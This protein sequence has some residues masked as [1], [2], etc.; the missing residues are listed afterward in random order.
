MEGQKFGCLQNFMIKIPKVFLP[1]EKLV[2]HSLVPDCQ[3]SIGIYEG[4]SPLALQPSG[5]IANPVLAPCDVTDGE[6]RLVADPFGIPYKDKH[7]LFFES[8]VKTQDGYKGKIALATSEGRGC[9]AL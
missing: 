4:D 1:K 6:S 5:S 7:Y 8:E 9:M 2:Q 3:W